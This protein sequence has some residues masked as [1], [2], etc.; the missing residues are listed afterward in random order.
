MQAQVAMFQTN[1]MPNLAQGETSGKNLNL[2]QDVW[3]GTGNK[4][5]L[6][7]SAHAMD[8][9]AYPWVIHN[10]YISCEPFPTPHT[11]L[12]TLKKCKSSLSRWESAVVEDVYFVTQDTTS[13]SF[14]TFDT[15]E[16]CNQL[17]C[18]PHTNQ[19]FIKHGID[20]VST[21]LELFDSIQ[22]ECKTIKT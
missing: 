9:R 16:G 18:I 6:G 3:S 2:Q 11:A 15:V 8:V 21:L 13:A 1:H 17:P 14:N 20:N 5:F 7:T 10:E 12:L 4:S 22:N 19:L